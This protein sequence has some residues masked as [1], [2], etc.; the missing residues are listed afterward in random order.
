MN[1][2]GESFS[3]WKSTV[4]YVIHAKN[5]EIVVYQKKTFQTYSL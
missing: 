2:E 4:A 1:R 3:I 5:G